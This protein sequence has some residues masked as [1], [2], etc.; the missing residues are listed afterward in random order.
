MVGALTFVI[1]SVLFTTYALEYP[2]HGDPRVTPDAL[3]L[4]LQQFEG[5][6]Q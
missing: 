3:E 6:Q 1:A 4:Y 5:S 2:F